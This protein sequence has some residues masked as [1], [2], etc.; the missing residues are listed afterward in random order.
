[1]GKWAYGAANRDSTPMKHCITQR[2]WV[3]AMLVTALLAAPALWVGFVGDDLIQRLRLEHRLPGFGDGFWSAYEFTPQSF[4]ARELIQQGLL[5]WFTDPEL[6]IHF[7]RPLTS[8]SLAL[9]A[10]CFGRNAAL[11]H[12]HSIAWLLLLA[13]A[14]ARLYQRWFAPAPALL[15]ALVFA[16]AG[17]HGMPTAWLASRHTLIAAALA[18]SS[19]WVWAKYREDRWQPGRWLAPSFLCASLLASESGLCGVVFLVAYELSAHVQRST[20]RDLDRRSHSVRFGSEPWRRR[21]A[22]G[23]ARALNLR[24]IW[25]AARSA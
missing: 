18:V 23:L 25:T 20:H 5:P 17:A 22:P 12:A 21:Q 7:L 19:L 4:P 14:S 16:M 10:W 3:W 6:R 1:M 15:S 9:D 2:A 11:A 24:T 13:A 8:A